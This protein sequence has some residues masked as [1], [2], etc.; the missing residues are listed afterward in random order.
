MILE[1]NSSQINQ[2]GVLV[3]CSYFLRA[4]PPSLHVKCGHWF[5]QWI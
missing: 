4:K 2:E 5:S 1:K 3:A